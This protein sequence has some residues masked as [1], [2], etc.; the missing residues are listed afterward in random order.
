[1]W[2]DSAGSLFLFGGLAS[3]AQQHK[4]RVLPF[5]TASSPDD[6]AELADLWHYDTT[7][8][9][10]Q[11]VSAGPDPYTFPANKSA[12]AAPWPSTRARASTWRDGALKDA[13]TEVVWMYGGAGAVPG[14]GGGTFDAA[15]FSDGMMGTASE[16]WQ[17]AYDPSQPAVPGRWT[18]ATR[19]PWRNAA[20]D[21]MAYKGGDMPQSWSA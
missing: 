18:L 3:D 2:T 11:L 20:D 17:Y 12:T 21:V 8:L 9:A 10:W 5:S 19:Y 6:V 15:D 14:L 1:M 7:R 13:G 16:L 4:S